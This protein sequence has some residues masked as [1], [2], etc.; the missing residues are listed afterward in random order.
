MTKGRAHS[1]PKAFLVPLALFFLTCAV[2]KSCTALD[3]SSMS[4][5]ASGSQHSFRPISNSNEISDSMNSKS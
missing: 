5:G 2:N 4:N 3:L 1:L